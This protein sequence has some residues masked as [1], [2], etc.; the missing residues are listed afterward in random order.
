MRLIIVYY[1]SR[2]LGIECLAQHYLAVLLD[3]DL[4]AGELHILN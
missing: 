4:C 3:Y 1:K 2:I